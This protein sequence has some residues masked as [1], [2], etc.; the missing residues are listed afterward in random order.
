MFRRYIVMKAIIFM[1]P[2]FLRFGSLNLNPWTVKK[3]NPMRLA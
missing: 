2:A 1:I 3:I